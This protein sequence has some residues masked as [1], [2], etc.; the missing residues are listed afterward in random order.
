M[1]VQKLNIDISAMQIYTQF[2]HL[3]LK[4]ANEILQKYLMD[5]WYFTV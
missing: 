1:A 5:I 2:L 3:S 4:C